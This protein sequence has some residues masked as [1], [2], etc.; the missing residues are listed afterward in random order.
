MT[1]AP[2]RYGRLDGGTIELTNRLISLAS[3]G[4]PKMYRT[5]SD[6]FAF[7]RIFTTTGEQVRAELSGVSLRY[8]AIVALGVAWLPAG[9]QAEQLGGHQLEDFV[10]LLVKRQA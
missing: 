10:T 9:Q 5:D 4:L 3:R 2:A 6:E 8:A 7:T 1:P